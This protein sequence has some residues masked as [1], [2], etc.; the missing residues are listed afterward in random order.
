MKSSMI[1][2]KNLALAAIISFSQATAFACSYVS[3]VDIFHEKS[4]A[5]SSETKNKKLQDRFQFTLNKFPAIG[6]LSIEENAY[7]PDLEDANA[8]A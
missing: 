6:S 7:A 5:T 2:Y 3:T 4:K 1:I 8:L